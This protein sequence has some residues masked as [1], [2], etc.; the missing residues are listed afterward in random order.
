MTNIIKFGLI[1][2]IVGCNQIQPKLKTD[3]SVMS[4]EDSL[5]LS[6]YKNLLGKT[7]GIEKDFINDLISTITIFQANELDTTILRFGAFDTDNVTDTISTRIFLKL[8]TVIVSSTWTKNLQ[9]LWFNKLK[10]PYLWINNDSLFEYKKRSKWVTFTIGYKHAVPEIYKI[11]DYSSLINSAVDF[12]VEDLQKHGI[13]VDKETYKQYLINFNGDL[14]SWGDPENRE[15]LFI[16]YDPAKRF[17]LY[18][19]D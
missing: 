9:L 14:I 3:L 10:N 7:S 5:L 18:Y 12:G 13:I 15:G 4:R 1:L 11:G 6:K 19:Q 16:W 17:V 2:I 8:D